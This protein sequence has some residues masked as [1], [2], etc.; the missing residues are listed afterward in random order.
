VK[1]LEEQGVGDTLPGS[2]H[3]TRGGGGGV[4]GCAGASRWD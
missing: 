2:Q 3:F 4:E 1:T